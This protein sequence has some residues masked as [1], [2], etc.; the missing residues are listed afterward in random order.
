MRRRESLGLAGS[1]AALPVVAR[2]QHAAMPVIDV[3]AVC[4]GLAAS[5]PQNRQK[6]AR[7]VSHLTTAFGELQ[8]S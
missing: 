2:A 3:V 4:T 8:S 1:V 5:G 7:A 6:L